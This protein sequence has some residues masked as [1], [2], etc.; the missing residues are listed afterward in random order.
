MNLGGRH[1]PAQEGALK[2]HDQLGASK[3]RDITL[4]E[5]SHANCKTFCNMTW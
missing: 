1:D 2:G 4:V 3:K 5:A